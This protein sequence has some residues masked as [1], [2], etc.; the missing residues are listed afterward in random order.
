MPRKKKPSAEAAVRDI[1]RKTRRRFSAE[2]KIRF[3]LEDLR[4]ENRQLEEVVAEITL[5][6]RLLQKSLTASGEEDDT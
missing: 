3:V 5:D 1:R 4:A 2:E 6:N